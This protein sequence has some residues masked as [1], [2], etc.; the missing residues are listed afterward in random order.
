MQ[1]WVGLRTEFAWDVDSPT[2]CRN[3]FLFHDLLSGTLW[4]AYV[5]V[6]PCISFFLGLH[7]CILRPELARGSR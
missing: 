2:R 6:I 5:P 4:R 1:V 3:T 7:S